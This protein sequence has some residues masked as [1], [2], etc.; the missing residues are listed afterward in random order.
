M[1]ICVGAGGAGAC[2]PRARVPEIYLI[3][4]FGLFCFKGIAFL[5]GFLRQVTLKLVWVVSYISPVDIY[6]GIAPGSW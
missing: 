5:V 3:V 2:G 1:G 4:Q 6:P